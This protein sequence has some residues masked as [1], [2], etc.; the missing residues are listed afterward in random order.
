MEVEE[1]EPRTKV[2]YVMGQG[3]SG[4]TILGVA[5]G[6][7]T[8]FFFAGELTSWLMTEARPVFGGRERASFWRRVRAEMPEAQPLFGGGAFQL[9]E[10]S[11]AAVRVDSRGARRRLRA[12]WA[13]VTERLYATV[14][15][16]SGADYVIDSSHLPMRARELQRLDG[17]ELYL[18]FL[19]RDPEA[20]VASHTRHLRERDRAGRRRRARQ[21]GF[22]LWSTLA[23]SSWVFLRQP[24][25]RRLLVRHEELLAD[26]E[27]VLA[28]IR[29]WTG[30]E[31]E[32][33]DL[34][35]LATGVPFQG[36][37]GLLR[38]TEVQ[39]RRR[40]ADPHRSSA[41][42]RGARVPLALVL[43]RLRPRV[44]AG[45]GSPRRTRAFAGDAR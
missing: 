4:S 15:C 24:Y 27:G 8:G 25:E 10:R 41:V 26:P 23:L 20:V 22:H 43:A 44:A 7:L 38:E 1:S 45:E 30:S 3:K 37:S 28:Q 6:N 33:P 19:V 5:L 42:L 40:P 29:D 17:V 35:A 16:Q 34:D 18:L 12:R 9:L 13:P 32:L 14:A 21:V 39:L 2:L 11:L 36:N 31:A